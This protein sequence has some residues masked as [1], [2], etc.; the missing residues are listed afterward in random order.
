MK[1]SMILE[2]C[3]HAE[4][5]T[6]FLVSLFLLFSGHNQPGGGFAGGL[7]ASSALCLAYVAGGP[8]GLRRLARVRPHV[9]LGV[10]LLLAVTTGLVSLVQGHDFLE[11]SILKV[12]LPVIG[13]AKTSSVPIVSA[14]GAGSAAAS[15][16][17]ASTSRRSRSRSAWSLASSSSPALTRCE[18]SR[19]IGSRSRQAAT[20]SALR[21]GEGSATRWPETRYV[22][23]SISVR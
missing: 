11:S 20:S 15:A 9:L 13:P 16:I 19:A 14:A 2:V 17:A 12:T 22:C 18:R 10:G 5:H 7:V 6:L 1:R 21:Y 4:M 3:V 23:A 8:T